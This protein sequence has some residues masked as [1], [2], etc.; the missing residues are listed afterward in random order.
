MASVGPETYSAWQPGFGAQLVLETPGRRYLLADYFLPPPGWHW[1]KLSPEAAGGATAVALAYNPGLIGI[2]RTRLGTFDGYASANKIADTAV[3]ARVMDLVRRKRLIMFDMGAPLARVDTIVEGPSA[4]DLRGLDFADKAMTV[5]KGLADVDGAAFGSHARQALV[6]LKD[7]MTSSPALITTMAFVFAAWIASHATGVLGLALDAALFGFVL[8][9]MGMSAFGW[10]ERL[11]GLIGAIDKARTR[12]DLQKCSE[13]LARLIVEIGV[14]V[15]VTLLTKA[16]GKAVKA[17]AKKVIAKPSGGGGGTAP[18]PQSTGGQRPRPTS[19][20]S[21]IPTINGR[22]PLNY[23]YAGKVHPSGVRFTKQ[24][25][26]DF[27]PHARA[28]VRLKG[29]TGAYRVDAAMANKAVGLKSTP[30]GYVWHHVEDGATMQLI[31][32][33]IHNAVRHS[34]GASFIKNGGFD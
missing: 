23:R 17:T 22:R 29:L 33:S 14:G 18:P 13:E 10:F 11:A 3:A 15:F 7:A 4:D 6:E 31:P 27:T 24:G 25:F 34:G 30:A 32:K 19:G 5:V 8:Y 20:T 2:I 21:A 12:G 28:Q 1:P 26:P 16:A 9:Q